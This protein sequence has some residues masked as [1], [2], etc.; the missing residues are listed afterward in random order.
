MCLLTSLDLNS[1]FVTFS[2][3]FVL[4]MW[5]DV[6]LYI[7]E[8]TSWRWTGFAGGSWSDLNL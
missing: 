2:I 8:G 7:A 3:F 1:F 5:L 4:K 6:T